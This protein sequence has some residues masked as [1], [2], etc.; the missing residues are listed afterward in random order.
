MFLSR[1][2]KI[3]TATQKDA[4][5]IVSQ[6]LSLA[7][8]SENK[9]LDKELVCNGV[10]AVLKDE[11]KGF[12]IVAEENN[13]IIGQ[14]MITVEWSDWRNKPIW[15]VQSVYVQKQWRN[16]TVFTQLLAFVRTQALEQNVAFLR[17]YVHHDNQTALQ[18]YEK[19]GWNKEPFLFYQSPL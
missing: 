16:K 19:T 13:Q 2:I 12:Y 3:R 11:N 5:V 7:Q 18:V 8:E 4:A 14:L 9:I 1:M 15:W 17:L 6:N 10:L